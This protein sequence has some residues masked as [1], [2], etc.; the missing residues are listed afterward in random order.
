MIHEGIRAGHITRDQI[1]AFRAAQLIDDLAVFPGAT[2]ADDATYC[3]LMREVGE[4]VEAVTVHRG[5]PTTE[6]ADRMTREA[7]EAAA[8][9][10]APRRIRKRT[11][12]ARRK[13]PARHWRV[14]TGAR[15]KQQ[16]DTEEPSAMETPY[17]SRPV[18]TAPR[19]Q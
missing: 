19:C 5:L 7:L 6:S 11:A 15:T 17:P 1:V 13:R 10:A 3:A 14:G 12:V 2:D 4:A 9:V 16:Q 8:I 18:V